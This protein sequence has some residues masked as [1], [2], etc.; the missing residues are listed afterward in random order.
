MPAGI[1]I[2]GLE[3]GHRH[4]DCDRSCLVP[5]AP[6]HVTRLECW[7]RRE[8]GVET[9]FRRTGGVHLCVEWQPPR[10]LFSWSWSWCWSCSETGLSSQEI[11]ARTQKQECSTSCLWG[12]VCWL[13]SLESANHVGPERRLKCR[14]LFDEASQK[15][16]YHGRRPW[17]TVAWGKR[18]AAPGNE[19]DQHGGRARSL[20]PIGP[21][22]EAATSRT[23]NPG[24]MWHR[25]SVIR[26][27]PGYYGTTGGDRK[28]LPVQPPIRRRCTT[29]AQSAAGFGLGALPA[30][31]KRVCSAAEIRTIY[32]GAALRLTTF[33]FALPQ[34]T[35]S[36]ALQADLPGRT[37]RTLLTPGAEP[38]DKSQD[39]A[40][41][42]LYFL[43]LGSANRVSPRAR[44]RKTTRICVAPG[45]GIRSAYWAAG[46]I[47]RRCVFR[48]VSQNHRN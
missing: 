39:T 33:A 41:G 5:P 10:V 35:M 23:S 22:A 24:P 47:H 43:P 34:A 46:Q 30:E 2:L 17:F 19:S 4:G 11:R 3:H 27:E 32:P 45:I 48:G 28:H 14:S 1:S 31:I 37:Q 16:G 18:S 13:L 8:W 40:A 38:G 25:M 42:M 15:L 26:R 44:T 12:P 21:P 6:E 9:L 29:M 7:I 36:S 20:N